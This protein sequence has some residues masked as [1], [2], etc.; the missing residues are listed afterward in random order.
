M[1]LN[2]LR[3]NPGAGK[4]TRR[5]GRGP[6]SGRGK[7]CGRGHKGQKARSGGMSSRGFEGGQMPFYRRLPK[8][9]F[10]NTRFKTLYSVVN[11][12]SLNI[13]ENGTRVTPKVLKAKGLVTNPRMPVKILGNGELAVKLDVVAHAFSEKARHAIEQQGGTCYVIG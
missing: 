10:N 4:T 8:K 5:K 2:Q 7:T 3:N 1:T 9:G 6:G 11:L 13:F 12:N